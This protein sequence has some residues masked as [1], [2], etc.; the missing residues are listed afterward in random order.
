MLDFPDSTSEIAL[1]RVAL[2]LSVYKTGWKQFL[3]LSPSLTYLSRGRSTG[4]RCGPDLILQPAAVLLLLL[5]ILL[6][7]KSLL[8]ACTQ[9]HLGFPVVLRQSIQQLLRLCDG[10]APFSDGLLVLCKFLGE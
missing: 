8:P 1:S 9:L 3:Q 10:E 7:P 5:H 6:Q 4:F 2:Q